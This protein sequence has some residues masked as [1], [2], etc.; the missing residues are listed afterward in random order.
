MQS[1][2]QFWLGCTLFSSGKILA[3]IA[4]K[5]LMRTSSER[6]FPGSQYGLPPDGSS[7]RTKF[8]VSRQQTLFQVGLMSVLLLGSRIA[9]IL[10]NIFIGCIN[11]RLARPSVCR[12]LQG[13]TFFSNR[14]SFFFVVST[15]TRHYLC[16]FFDWSAA[17]SLT[18]CCNCLG[19]SHH[20][21]LWLEWA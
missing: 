18:N 20:L 19:K 17:H 14:C 15:N 16:V 2:Q 21:S 9:E 3:S 10:L 11:G 1:G 7:I 12:K 8:V 5:S 13:L 6:N 4:M